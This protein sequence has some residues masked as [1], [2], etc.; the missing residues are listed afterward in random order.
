MRKKT[1]QRRL[2]PNRLR[3]W[4]PQP[5][6]NVT[7]FFRFTVYEV[8]ARPGLLPF[9]PCVPDLDRAY[10]KRIRLGA[11]RMSQQ[12]YAWAHSTATAAGPR[13]MARAFLISLCL[14]AALIGVIGRF[15][16]TRESQPA[17]REL[18][19]ELTPGP[20]PMTAAPL[21]AVHAEPRQDNSA[22]KIKQRSDRLTR[23]S[24]AQP[25]TQSSDPAGR[26]SIPSNPAG[27]A[28]VPLAAERP[29]PQESA[30]PI[31]PRVLDWLARYRTYPLEARRA[32][33]EGVVQLRVT[34]MSDG[35]LVDARVEQSSG[36]LVLDRA[37]LDLLARASP[38][39][40]E[41]TTIGQ[42]ELQLPIVY[43]M[44]APSS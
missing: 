44:R 41:F 6:S 38:L 32:R 17:Q 42:V 12:L 2:S 43:R 5:V 4:G 16:S 26:T 30:R 23:A 37:A 19:L 18:R 14:H 31:E 28:D 36:H 8:G 7:A 11:T 21:A 13:S 24:A 1:S 10:T 39:P 3:R 22:R 34:L 9:P 20:R 40:D 29:E 15:V 27:D 25:A 35:R 33:I